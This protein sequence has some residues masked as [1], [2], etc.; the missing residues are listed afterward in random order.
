MQISWKDY[1]PSLHKEGHFFVILFAIIGTIIS[2]IIP[3]LLW[4]CI[5][6]TVFCALFFRDPIRIAPIG[7]QYII[8]PADGLVQNIQDIAPPEELN[9]GI[10]EMT[11]VSIFLSVFD[12][13]VNRTPA[14]GKIT[15]LFY[16]PGKFLNAS[17]DKASKDNERQVVAMK[18][19]YGDKDIVFVQIAGFIARRIVCDLEQNVEVKAGNRFGIIRFGSRMDVYMPKGTNP[20]VII[21]QRV[22]GGETILAD[23]SSDKEQ[24][25]GEVR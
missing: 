4:P 22:V 13:H 12:V 18:T 3:S 24:L 6:I 23:L 1:L 16:H 9:L 21:G 11:R 8:S 20:Q 5:L 2:L 10:E 25:M 7:D 19:T 15:S 14:S 17:L